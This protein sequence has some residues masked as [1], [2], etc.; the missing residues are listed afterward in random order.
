VRV[1]LGAGVG[2][3][4]VVAGDRIRA[5][6]YR[7]YGLWLAA[8]GFAAVYL[9]I[10]AAAALYTLVSIPV[11]F[12][13]M[14]VVVLS[15]A[16]LGHLRDSESFVVLAALGGYAAPLLLQAETA[17]NLFGL[18]YLGLLSGAALG[19]AYRGSWQYLA[20]L[21]VLGGT[22]LPI[23]STGDP[24][25]HGFYL[26]AL[27]AAA[28]TVSRRRDWHYLSI[29]TV[30][31]GW[32]SLWAGSAEWGISGVVLAAYAAALWLD[33]S[34][35]SVGVTDWTSDV[36]EAPDAFVRGM[37]DLT[38]LALTLA[39]P[40]VFFAFAMVG[41]D[42]SVY[43]DS[44]DL[45]GFALAVVLGGLYVGQSVW[46]RPGSRSG[47][48]EWSA[49]LGCA[50]WL[51]APAVLWDG[52]ALAR[53]WLVQSV[54]LTVAGVGFKHAI[55]RASGLAAFTLAVITYWYTVHLRPE[56]DPAFISGWALT[57]LAACLGLAA[58]SLAVKRLER[59]ESWEKEI[60]PFLYLASAAF[61]LGWG[62]VEIL[63]F[64][65]L[66]G[67]ADRW[68]LASD[69]SISSFWMAYAAVLLTA[70]FWLKQAPVRWAGLGMALIAAGKVFLY[71]LSQLSEL[72]RILSF[73]LLAVVLLSLSFSYQRWHRDSKDG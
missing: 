7:T 54:L 19:V 16:V 32:I 57:G 30:T 24:H 49:A 50:F 27:V 44:R 8:G 20:G 47:S 18:G 3:V 28:L 41:L 13:L 35:A 70:G 21:A 33:D 51:A 23:A 65:Y 45:I 43:R 58:W 5:L 15:A 68:A 59:I 48:R 6:G 63:R 10:W 22:L 14:V 4:A 55:A 52:V 69:L 46:S 26:V 38:G 40:W 11:A 29:F 12:A 17:S 37:D 31:L 60:R 9:S 42:E 71:D 25:L 67:E 72:Y 1:L 39:P 2:V 66:L 34:I 61:F 64:Y 73:V 53:A 56:V 62:T 36:T